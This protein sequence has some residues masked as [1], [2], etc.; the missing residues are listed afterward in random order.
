MSFITESL[1]AKREEREG[2]AQYGSSVDYITA[3]T[4][5]EDTDSSEESSDGGGSFW[6]EMAQDITKALQHVGQA[7]S[8]VRQ[9]EQGDLEQVGAETGQAAADW[10]NV[11]GKDYNDLSVPQKLVH[12]DFRGALNDFDDYYTNNALQRFDQLRDDDGNVT[13]ESASEA[14]NGSSYGYDATGSAPVI[15]PNSN[16]DYSTTEFADNLPGH[17]GRDFRDWSN[18]VDQD[19]DTVWE[20]GGSEGKWKLYEDA[21]ANPAMKVA[22]TPYMPAPARVIAGAVAAPSFISGVVNAA[23]DGY[24]GEAGNGSGGVLGAANNVVDTVIGKP[25]E[26]VVGAVS[27]PGQTLSAIYDHPA[28]LWNKV[29]EPGMI[30]EG[31]IRAGKKGYDYTRSKETEPAPEPEQAPEP[32]SEGIQTGSEYDAA[33]NEACARYGLDPR[34]GHAVAQTESQHGKSTSNVFGVNGISDPYESIDVG[35]KSLKRCIDDNG[36]DIDAGLREYNGNANPDYTSTVHQIE[37]EYGG[38]GRAPGNSASWDI[39]MSE[40]GNTMDNHSVG[41]VEAVTKLGKNN[42]FLGR[43]LNNGVVGVP[44]LIE[45]AKAEGRYLDYD[46]S[47]LERGDVIVFD[48]DEHVMMYA[49]DGRI[50]GNSSSLD[51]IVE[52]GLN[53]QGQTPTGI[54]KAGGA[55]GGTGNVRNLARDT[56]ET[57]ADNNSHAFDEVN[58]AAEKGSD[59]LPSL[60]DEARAETNSL[61][62]PEEIFGKEE[63]QEVKV[64][65]Q[66]G[67]SDDAYAER[68]YNQGVKIGNKDVPSHNDAA[69]I[70][71]IKDELGE[72]KKQQDIALG[73]PDRLSILGL[74]DATVNAM[75][76]LGDKEIPLKSFSE[77]DRLVLKKA[78]YEGE[79]VNASKVAA[80]YDAKVLMDKMIRQRAEEIKI[81]QAQLGELELRKPELKEEPELRKP[82]PKEEP[83]GEDLI[84][85]PESWDIRV[86]DDFQNKAPKEDEGLIDDPE[87]WEL[88]APKDT[89][90]QMKRNIEKMLED[91]S[92][93]GEWI[94]PEK[95]SNSLAERTFPKNKKDRVQEEP[96]ESVEPITNKELR[97]RI[98]AFGYRLDDSNFNEKRAGGR[99]SY[100]DGNTIVTKHQNDTDAQVHHLADKLTDDFNITEQRYDQE[101][102]DGLKKMWER[103]KYGVDREKEYYHD[104]EGIHSPD[105]R[106]FAVMNAIKEHLHDPE[107]AKADF[108]QFDRVIEEKIKES[109]LETQVKELQDGL[110]R[111]RTQSPEAAVEASLEAYDPYAGLGRIETAKQMVSN[112]LTKLKMQLVDEDYGAKRFD[113]KKKAAGGSVE[114]SKD[115]LYDNISYAKGTGKGVAELMVEPHKAEDAGKIANSI[116]KVFGEGTVKEHKS[117]HNIIQGYHQAVKG[118]FGN[119]DM[120]QALNAYLAANTLH[121]NLKAR[122][123]RLTNEINRRENLIKNKGIDTELNMEDSAPAARAKGY[124][125]AMDFGGKQKQKALEKEL[126]QLRSGGYQM[127]WRNGVVDARKVVKNAPQEVKDAAKEIYD[128]TDNLLNIAEKSGLIS[129]K[130]HKALKGNFLPISKAFK[131]QLESAL[132]EA[133]VPD[134]EIKSAMRTFDSIKG[135]NHDIHNVLEDVENYTQTLTN[136]AARNKLVIEPMVKDLKA[137]KLGREVDPEKVT[138]ESTVVFG[139]ENG[140]RVAYDVQ[141]PLIKQAMDVIESPEETNAI[142]RCWAG[143]MDFWRAGTVN[144][145]A[146]TATQLV[147]Q[148]VDGLLLGEGKM[149]KPVK[150][151]I[152]GLK[153]L[154]SKDQDYYDFKVAGISHSNMVALDKGNVTK[155][156]KQAYD[157]PLVT[158]KGFKEK[159]TAI[160]SAV[161]SSTR[162]GKFKSDLKGGADFED[163]VMNAK[164]VAVDFGRHGSFGKKVNR[165]GPFFNAAIQGTRAYIHALFRGRNRKRAAI[166]AGTA[167]GMTYLNWLRIHNEPWYQDMSDEEKSRSWF[168]SEHLT[169]PKSQEL[170]ALC[171]AFENLFNATQD[172]KYGKHLLETAKLLYELLP[173]MP[174]TGPLTAVELKMNY[175]LFSNREIVADKYKKKDFDNSYD[176]NKTSTMAVEI[177]RALGVN[178]AQVEFTSKG[179]GG[180][181]AK[182]LMDTADWAK[183]NRNLT[184][185]KALGFSAKFTP[186]KHSSQAVSDFYELKE[187]TA[188]A[189]DGTKESPGGTNKYNTTAMKKN[190]R[191]KQMSASDRRD[192]M[193]VE[194][195]EHDLKNIKDKNKQQE[196]IKK[197]MRGYKK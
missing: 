116:N 193:F 66:P 43:E 23:S 21:V 49:G 84:D 39:D 109:G 188:K 165:Y 42:D 58:N 158:W 119:K 67:E 16:Y 45:D 100:V 17:I 56:E 136:E 90:T 186:D 187:K 164:R 28:D 6:G 101:L 32:T 110:Y 88:E 168:L 36:G 182:Q 122:E 57:A 3:N 70:N 95:K 132:K 46:P 89:D 13:P 50:V 124:M 25:L 59:N 133:G 15:D 154:K 38:S 64:E 130:V 52:R 27:H 121:R 134:A 94:N 37:N 135:S 33:I 192:Y 167:V 106:R 137:F 65:R 117:L 53:E 93:R 97:D 139:W 153:S 12:G 72:L 68:L 69:V 107:Q 159:A 173:G 14:E 172:G 86:K 180:Q 55:R 11:E 2:A 71:Q 143:M 162:L 120:L 123:N 92:L 111:M 44:K 102:N 169:I 80:D 47:K 26:E 177:A 184:L 118:K 1:E 20:S 129:N 175:D 34:L 98:E 85:D 24:N 74:S 63:K 191:L 51:R 83:A 147:R 141:D 10:Y 114:H 160:P 145:P 144:T 108:P 183:G 54:I 161:E 179:V 73:K 22:A 19:F 149:Y 155:S 76:K 197:A 151:E 7:M 128:Y 48:G 112:G 60:E 79:T 35:V 62:D 82:E 174:T 140:K 77:T 75:K 131:P 152:D 190:F 171:G 8:N 178:P 185:G 40:V 148:F 113:E 61:P 146:F 196:Y 176:K 163:A 166:V 157:K 150:T 87:S 138:D 4:P 31:G 99:D 104:D 115:T 81:K 29:L 170:G 91:P 126:H 189:F 195:V 103:N 30:V 9:Q 142:M 127:P 41:C 78:G 156:V 96:E 194:K 181:M 125:A 5:V 18:L 105:N